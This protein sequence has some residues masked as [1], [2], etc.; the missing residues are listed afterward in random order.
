MPITEKNLQILALIIIGTMF[1]LSL[2][3][4]YVVPSI[5]P[6]ATA[7]LSFLLIIIVIGAISFYI[8]KGSPLF[9]VG[10]FVLMLAF[11]S[12][13]IATV[14]TFGEDWRVVAILEANPDQYIHWIRTAFFYG[15]LPIA[16]GLSLCMLAYVKYRKIPRRSFGN[17]LLL[18]TGGFFA[19]WGVHY[20]QVAYREYFKASSWAAQSNIG[21]INDSLQTIYAAYGCVGILWLVAGIFL[22][23]MSIYTLY[24]FT[25]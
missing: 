20:F 25:H 8:T 23:A 2:L 22:I 16:T 5:L 18:M 4:L 11:F 24:K 1:S 19:I 17:W 13:F 15:I 12:S 14:G 10:L 21:H 6:D 3:R 7:V 9:G